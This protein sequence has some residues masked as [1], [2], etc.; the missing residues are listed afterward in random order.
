MPGG[1]AG[2]ASPGAARRCPCCHGI[3]SGAH[4][5]DYYLRLRNYQRLVSGKCLTACPV[6]SSAFKKVLPLAACDS[7]V[8]TAILLPIHPYRDACFELVPYLHN[9]ICEAR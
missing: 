2:A 4:V 7:T 6:P 1:C 9:H 5:Y 8:M 3:A